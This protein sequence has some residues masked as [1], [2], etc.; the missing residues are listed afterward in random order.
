MSVQS[1]GFTANIHVSF[2]EFWKTSQV[3]EHNTTTFL[4]QIS[5]GGIFI[6]KYNH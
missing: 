2:P 5:V 1:E 6:F 4:T 3:R